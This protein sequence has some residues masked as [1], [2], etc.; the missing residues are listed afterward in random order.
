MRA[1]EAARPALP[2]SQY[3]PTIFFVFALYG[4][5]STDQPAPA[6]SCAS[7]EKDYAL[8]IADA[9]LALQAYLGTASPRTRIDLDVCWT[10][11]NAV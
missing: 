9:R 3:R 11:S 4:Y 6:A 2:L 7:A 10:R 1:C 8:V 5:S